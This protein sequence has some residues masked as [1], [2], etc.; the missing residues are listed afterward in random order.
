MRADGEELE[1]DGRIMGT[2]LCEHCEHST[3]REELPGGL[4]VEL[5]C[6]R[7][8]FSKELVDGWPCFMERS[9]RL[10]EYCG[11]TGKFFKPKQVDA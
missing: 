9:L 6:T 8:N 4:Q 1:G 7:P 2:G 3:R 10:M 11:P 5:Y